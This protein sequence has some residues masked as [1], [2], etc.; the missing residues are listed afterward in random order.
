MAGRLSDYRVDTATLAA[1]PGEGGQIADPLIHER[2]LKTIEADDAGF[3]GAHAKGSVIKSRR[4]WWQ[5]KGAGRVIGR[6]Q[7]E[8]PDCSSSCP[9]VEVPR[10]DGC[11]LLLDLD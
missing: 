1:E 9:S 8:R 11:I 4:A 10:Y 6:R 7:A 5:S 2:R 3:H